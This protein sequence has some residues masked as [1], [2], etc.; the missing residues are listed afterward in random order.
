MGHRMRHSRSKE[1]CAAYS[2]S[3]EPKNN[4]IPAR[5]LAILGVLTPLIT[6]CA[7]GLNLNEHVD[8]A[9]QPITGP[10]NIPIPLGDISQYLPAGYTIDCVNNLTWTPNSYLDTAQVDLVNMSVY[11][12]P[13]DNVNGHVTV[14]AGLGELNSYG[15]CLETVDVRG[16]FQLNTGGQSSPGYESVPAYTPPQDTTPPVCSVIG[17]DDWGN[18]QVDCDER[19]ILM[20]ANGG[21][22]GAGSH[23]PLHIPESSKHISN[24]TAIDSAGNPASVGSFG[25]AVS[26]APLT[27]IPYTYDAT[28]G[29]Y[30]QI[31]Q[32]NS[33]GGVRVATVS[34]EASPVMLNPDGRVTILFSPGE[35]HKIITFNDTTFGPRTESPIDRAIA[36]PPLVSVGSAT[37]SESIVTIPVAC[38][39]VHDEPCTIRTGLTPENLQDAGTAADQEN[40]VVTLPASLFSQN[41]KVIVQGCVD[42]S[43]CMSVQVEVAPYRP[44]DNIFLNGPSTANDKD[45]GMRSAFVM[46]QAEKPNVDWDS[47]GSERLIVSQENPLPSAPVTKWWVDQWRQLNDWVNGSSSQPSCVPV[48]NNNQVQ[49]NCHFP[50]QSPGTVT[51]VLTDHSNP[52]QTQAFTINIPGSTE[53][54][55]KQILRELGTLSLMTITGAIPVAA[56]AGYAGLRRRQQIEQRELE[57]A[58][59]EEVLRGRCISH[60]CDSHLFDTDARSNMQERLT[61]AWNE[62]GLLKDKKEKE[63]FSHLLQ[64]RIAL[65]S[66]SKAVKER[67]MK[68]AYDHLYRHL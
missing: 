57:A 9:N 46:G 12:D 35:T 37:T 4:H 49:V 59:Q 2:A 38:D 43:S 26:C 30:A 68:E 44:F 1:G 25:S 10:S 41:N 42:G 15:V 48:A 7:A 13:A 40:A 67:K 24:V 63:H 47:T 34:G 19:V 55:W 29:R 6:G 51:V 14:N 32:C 20:D 50:D 18:A 62:V 22:I 27:D 54:G 5:V 52:V 58:Q 17:P 16:T 61:S 53:P 31:V 56:V 23:V 45:G 66:S 39:T 60:I 36:Q 28:T 65:H 8:F 64:A 21:V 3:T 33:L 11:L